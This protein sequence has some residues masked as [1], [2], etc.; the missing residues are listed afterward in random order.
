MSEGISP[1]EANDR[2]TVYQVFEGCI[3]LQ[4]DIWKLA[5][6]LPY[7][8]DENYFTSNHISGSVWWVIQQIWNLL[9]WR[10][11]LWTSCDRVSRANE[12]QKRTRASTKTIWIVL[13][14]DDGHQWLLW[15]LMDWGGYRKNQQWTQWHAKQVIYSWCFANMLSWITLP[16][17]VD[18]CIIWYMG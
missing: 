6:L 13:Q 2:L 5:C 18:T 11:A 12:N 3:P 8:A 7:T 16:C 10:T 9:C 17:I 4:L 14:C 1:I 15:Y